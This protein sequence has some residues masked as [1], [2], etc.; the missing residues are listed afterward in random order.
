M[1][2][3]RERFLVLD[4][5]AV[6]D[7]FASLP[8][9][10][11]S[12]PPQASVGRPVTTL[13][14]LLV[15]VASFAIL[16]RAFRT[17]SQP[18]TPIGSGS[19]SV[20]LDSPI[21]VGDA[22]N[23][24]ASGASA[25]WVSALPAEGPPYSLVR[26]D[27]ITGDVVARIPVPALPTWEVGGG[28]LVA[29]PDGVWVTGAVDRPGGP[30]AIVFR[31][32][33]ATNEVAEQIDLGPGVGADLWVDGKG[34]WVLAFGMGQGSERMEVV[35]LDPATLE[36]VARI[37]L[38][39]AWAKQVFASDGSIWVH[40]NLGDAADGVRPDVLFRIDPVTNEFVGTL[41]LPT[42]EFSLA[43]D[44]TS[45]WQRAPDGVIR[46]D[47]AG[48][49]TRVPVEGMEDFCCS[50][51]A[52]D[53]AGGLWVIARAPGSGRVQ[54]VHVTAGGEIDDRAEARVPDAVLDSVTIAFDPEH[55][56][57]WLAQYEDTVTP[58]RLVGSESA[59]EVSTMLW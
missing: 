58:L 50:H 13:V 12:V 45:I 11:V 22:P 57:I 54:V 51:I 49:P 6:P 24:L 43:V 38:P 31:V 36:E 5:V 21:E 19:F 9:Q 2:D 40:G 15:A 26:L 41:A 18:E 10:P 29:L 28:G 32:D 16:V 34:M 44:G 55:Q 23:A 25:V 53:G 33:P 46:V 1:T 56:T 37:Q 20:E 35:R 59:R 4:D 39:S 17:A 48:S 42:A 7:R 3:L 47:P 52:S 14:A 27:P 30:H 8:P